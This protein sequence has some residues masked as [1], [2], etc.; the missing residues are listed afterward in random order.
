MYS[1]RLTMAHSALLRSR[2]LRV[3]MTFK[4][5]MRASGGGGSC[6]DGASPVGRNLAEGAAKRRN[7]WA[8]R[9]EV[10]A[11]FGSKP[12]FQPW[13]PHAIDC[14]V[15]FGTVEEADGVRLACPPAVEAAIFSQSFTMDLPAAV[16]RVEGP[17]VFAR[18]AKGY[19]PA[20]VFHEIC[21]LAPQGRVVEIDAD[22]LAPMEDPEVVVAL[23]RS[24]LEG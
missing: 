17:V 13:V 22:H 23:V 16:R 18:A 7:H 21:A 1:S 4:Q 12:L 20:E 9:E 3:K 8:S 14:Y 6:I 5:S 15:G 2:R 19:M 10:R 11:W 24:V